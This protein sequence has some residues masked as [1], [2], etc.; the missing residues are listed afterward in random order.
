ML[1]IGRE[2]AYLKPYQP[3]SKKTEEEHSDINM[4]TLKANCKQFDTVKCKSNQVQFH[5][6]PK[7]DIM[8]PVILIS[9]VL[10]GLC[11]NKFDIS[12]LKQIAHKWLPNRR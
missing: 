4:W 6:R 10:S 12:C 1:P 9:D 3:Q 8:S 11:D 7:R 5:S 2:T